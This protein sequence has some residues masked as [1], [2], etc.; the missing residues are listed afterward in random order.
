MNGRRYASVLSERLRYAAASFPEYLATI[1]TE[2][3][4][5]VPL[6]SLLLEAADVVAQE[7]GPVKFTNPKDPW[8]LDLDDPKQ[9]RKLE[10]IVAGF[11][12]AGFLLGYRLARR[13]R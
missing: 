2:T 5:T 3:G 11:T 4:V 10:T 13:R 8:V 12:L 6:R 1:E 9:A 7:G